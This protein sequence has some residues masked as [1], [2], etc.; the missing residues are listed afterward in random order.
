ML[1]NVAGNKKSQI[2]LLEVYD[3]V[4]EMDLIKYTHRYIIM[5]CDQHSR[6]IYRNCK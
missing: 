4:G 5:D 2:L 3:V 1:W 6:G